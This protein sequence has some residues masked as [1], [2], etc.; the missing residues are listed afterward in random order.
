MNAPPFLLGAGLAFW[1]WQSGNLLVGIALGVAIEAL[2][3]AR[4]RLDLGTAEH[5]TIADLS[6]IGFV[7]LAALISANRGIAHGILQAFVWLPAAISPILLAQYS[8]VEGRVPLSALLR[9]VRK[10][11]RERPD[12]P[13]PL[14]DVS[15]PYFALTLLAAGMANARG[16]EYYAGVVAG[17]ACLLYAARRRHANLLAATAML[18]AATGLGYV[19]HLGLAQAHLMFI[20]WVMDLNLVRTADPD[21]FRVRTEIGTLGRLKAYDAI[22]LRVYA[23]PG[24]GERMRLLHRN[25]YNTYLGTTWIARDAP[26][27]PLESEA[28]NE[29][30]ILS[31]LPGTG[32]VRMAARFDLGRTTLAL[33][34]GTVR[35]GGFPATAMQRNAMGSVHAFLG[36]QWAPFE[37]AMNPAFSPSSAPTAED[38]AVPVE[39]RAVL[40]SVATE[41][42]LGTGSAA[43]AVRTLER[44][45]QSFRYSLYRDR[46]VPRGE[47]AIGDFLR[48]TRAGHCEYFAAATTLLLRAAGVPAR[49]ATGYAMV[50]YSRLEGAFVVRS[51]HAHAWTQAWI[52][53]RWVDLDTTPPDWLPEE[54]AGAPVWQGLADLARYLGFR[55]SQRGEFKAGDGWYALLAVLAVVLAWRVLRGRK[56]VT[57]EQAPRTPARPHPG[58]DSEFGALAGLLPARDPAE[59]LAEWQQRIAG[60][61]PQAAA[62]AFQAALRL[63]RRLRFD[64]AGLAPPERDQLRRLCGELRVALAAPV[65]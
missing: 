21:P 25:S 50:E 17:A 57:A 48:R 19:G 65:R 35:L 42:G 49:Y 58:D 5:S 10:L 61:I 64:P 1:G 37:A 36:V 22:V 51:R 7:L 18:A 12:T 32:E 33:P 27:L 39:E 20:D 29:T 55:W 11:K 46:S 28:D 53:G 6:T 2:R 26:M 63:H 14:V 41:L 45:F 56:R 16:P 59:T 40:G 23:D 52:D 4:P 38:L 47:T 60:S 8:S 62:D 9:Y 44:H 43:D 3:L 34:P 13:D 31:P 15:A 30:W 54:E 24:S